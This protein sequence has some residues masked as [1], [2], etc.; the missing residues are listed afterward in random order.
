MTSPR[1]HGESALPWV[2]RSRATLLFGSKEDL[3]ATTETTGTAAVVEVAVETAA[4][5]RPTT[6]MTMKRTRKRSPRKKRTKILR[7][8]RRKRRRKRARSKTARKKGSQNT[9]PTMEVLQ[10]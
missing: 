3:A 9:T 6:T 2:I 7:R 10:F 5:S 1:L 8:E 4:G